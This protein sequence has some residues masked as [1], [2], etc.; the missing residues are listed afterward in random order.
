MLAGKLFTYQITIIKLSCYTKIY[1]HQCLPNFL[2]RRK[3]DLSHQKPNEKGFADWSPFVYL[4]Q[5][6]LAA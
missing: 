4:A 3:E 5:Y 2:I 6:S 1:G